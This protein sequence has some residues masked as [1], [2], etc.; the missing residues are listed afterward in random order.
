[1][2]ATRQLPIAVAEWE[3]G[4]ESIDTKL[5]FGY[6]NHH[7]RLVSVEVN[8]YLDTDITTKLEF[9]ALNLNQDTET[10]PNYELRLT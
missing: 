6:R 4:K 9:R 8:S 1:M 10:P 5:I 2:I 3:K 7:E